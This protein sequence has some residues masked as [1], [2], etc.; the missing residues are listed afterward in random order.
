M[1]LAARAAP[2]LPEELRDDPAEAAEDTAGG[3]GMTSCVP[4]SLPRTLLTNDP[5]AAWVGG[6]GTTAGVEERTLPLSMRRRS[7]DESVEGGGASN[8]GAGRWSF[9]GWEVCRSGAGTGGSAT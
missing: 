9:A 3:G 6:G 7:R 5:L 1:T 8:E 2:D 4:K